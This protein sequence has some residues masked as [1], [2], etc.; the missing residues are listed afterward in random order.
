MSHTI[1]WAEFSLQPHATEQALLDAS[2]VLQRDFL[3]AQPGFVARQ[4]L[5]LSEGHYADLVTWTTSEAA[6]AAMQNASAAPA[7]KGYFSLMRVDAA[8]RTGEMLATYRS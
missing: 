2:A 3:D 6:H 5:K 8:P 1:E 4:L 7:C